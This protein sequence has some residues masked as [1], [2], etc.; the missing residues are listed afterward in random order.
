MSLVLE[1]VSFS[2]ELN[3]TF[4]QPTEELSF[5]ARK[6]RNSRRRGS[7]AILNAKKRVRRNQANLRKARTALRSLKRRIR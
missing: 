6:I 1:N 7:K 3:D 2:Q 4:Q 5:E